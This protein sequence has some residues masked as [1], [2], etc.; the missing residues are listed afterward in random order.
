M[1]CSRVSENTP[2]RPRLLFYPC[3][4][5]LVAICGKEYY[6]KIVIGENNEKENQSSI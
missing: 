3:Y 1:L 2:L 6:N 4:K 5:I